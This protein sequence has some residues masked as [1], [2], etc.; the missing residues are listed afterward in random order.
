MSYRIELRPATIRALRKIDASSQARIK[1]AISLLA[2]DPHPPGAASL[3]GR[4]GLR[5]R[6]GDY[7]VIYTLQDQVLVIVA[8]TKTQR[9][10]APAET[11]GAGR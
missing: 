1:A 2:I 6:V 3:R 10:K 4:D 5:A 7:R 9:Q 11:L 8:I